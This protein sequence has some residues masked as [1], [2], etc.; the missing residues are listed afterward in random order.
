[1]LERGARPEEVSATVE[2]GEEFP[3]RF[4]RT[5]FRRN[6]RFESEWRGRRYSTKQIE[7]YAV[8]EDGAWLVITVI[9]RYF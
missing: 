1:M 6:F 4:G 2:G 3:A 5:G 8:F 7:A 9:C